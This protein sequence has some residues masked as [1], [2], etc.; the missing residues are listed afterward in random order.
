MTWWEWI[1]DEFSFLRHKRTDVQKDLSIIHIHMILH[2]FKHTSC[3]LNILTRKPMFFNQPSTCVEFQTTRTSER[4]WAKQCDSFYFLANQRPSLNRTPF[5][6]PPTI[7]VML[8]PLVTR[9]RTDHQTIYIITHQMGLSQCRRPQRAEE[10]GRA[11][12]STGASGQE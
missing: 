4:K 8:R 3:S 12:V 9:E 5:I 7:S 1:N 6:F 10:K 11:S 2:G